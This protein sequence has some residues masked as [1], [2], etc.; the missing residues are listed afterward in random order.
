MN[1]D[2]M[3]IFGEIIDYGLCVF[4]N[5]FY[6]RMVFSFIDI[7][8]WYVFVNQFNIVY[9]NLGV[10]VNVLFFLIDEEEVIVSVKVE[11]VLDWFLEDFIGVYFEM[12]GNKLGIVNQV[13]E[14]W[15]LVN[16]GLKL[17]VK[18]WVDYI[19]FFIELRCGGDLINKL[20]EEEVFENWYLRW[21]KVWLRGIFLIESNVLMV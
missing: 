15:D 11:E 1:I 6:F 10:L 2:N 9:W 20:R 13:E 8:G 5:V 19:N 7:D 12:M 3:V 14:D 17:L 16:F 18:W 4:M 21:E